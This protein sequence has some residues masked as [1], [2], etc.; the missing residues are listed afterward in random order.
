LNLVHREIFQVISPKNAR[1][2]YMAL[3]QPKL[4]MLLPFPT[5]C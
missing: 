3:K 5:S 1:I 2:R 4:S